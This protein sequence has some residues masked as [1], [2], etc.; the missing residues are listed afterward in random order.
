MRNP[1]SRELRRRQA[2]MESQQRNSVR[3][4]AQ[5]PSRDEIM[6]RGGLLEGL[7]PGMVSRLAIASLA[8]GLV[9]VGAAVLGLLVEL[10]QHDLFLGIVIVLVAAVMAGTALS[11]TAPAFLTARGDRK[12]QPR[13][14]QGPLVG[15]SRIS[16]TPTLATVAVTVGKSVEQFRVRREFFERVKSGATV[17]GLT[18]TP[19]L[20]CVQ[21]LTVIRRDRMAVMKEPPV[22]RAM[23]ISVWLPIISLGSL[24][25]GLGV[26]C[27]IG[28]VLPLGN[29]PFHPLVA[30]VLAAALAGAVAL[31]TRW[32]GQR[33]VAQL[34][35]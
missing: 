8:G 29:N 19:G 33:L 20:N 1:G 35:L 16:P 14:I 25:A 15:A 5:A 17:V 23:L 30:L 31:G 27:L 26:G 7:T 10:G 4:R 28:V 9:L 11:I 6:R 24:V 2:R 18:V 32:Y 34:G 3:E 22:S 13:T 12:A 21:T